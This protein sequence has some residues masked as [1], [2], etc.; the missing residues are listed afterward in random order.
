[1]AVGREVLTARV[2][3][4]WLDPTNPRLGRRNTDPPKSQTQLLKLMRDWNI[5]EL[6]TS[7]VES[8]FWTQE[9]LV[10]V[11][12]LRGRRVQSVVVEGNR[13]LAALKTL[14]ATVDGSFAS[15]FWNG[16]VA[17]L[18][19]EAAL[20]TAVP[21]YLVDSRDD[22]DAYLGFRHVT[23]IKQWEPAEKAE[24]IGR[25]V[26][27][28][29]MSFDE[30]RRAIGS[31]T[32]T[33]RL[34]YIAFRILLQFDELDTPIP[35]EMVE[36]RFSVM[37]LCLRE[38]SVRTFLGISEKADQARLRQPVP[39]RKV[40]ELGQFGLWLFGTRTRPPLF[41]DSRRV[42]DFA[43]ALSNRDAVKY[44]RTGRNVTLDQALR[45]S[46]LEKDD[47]VERVKIATDEVEQA[48]SR[49]HLYLDDDEVKA[50]VDRFAASAG[51]LLKKFDY[52]I[53][54]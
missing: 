45:H 48:L 44:L 43:R 26:D 12:E 19:A 21:Y 11:R 38:A 40:E 33:V 34:N 15:P 23:G 41:T 51:E 46:G 49:V 37:Y 29:G 2:D 13:R 54:G 14:K 8:G 4:L 1:V 6:A 31:K 18:D 47:V 9:A 32:P 39:D 36:D 30:V 17:G 50:A 22:V 20:F 7:F 28:R 16:L 10:V 35:I 3:D 52:T 42:S 53:S 24:Y 27:S 5:E 25:L